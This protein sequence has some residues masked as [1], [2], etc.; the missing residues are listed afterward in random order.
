M[1]QYVKIKIIPQTV[2]LLAFI[3]LDIINMHFEYLYKMPLSHAQYS[4]SEG[5]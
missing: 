5:Q 4:F 1:N 3:L 2:Y